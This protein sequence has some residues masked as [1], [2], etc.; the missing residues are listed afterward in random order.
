MS[1]SMAETHG[2]NVSILMVLLSFATVA[3]VVLSHKALCEVS[4]EL[5]LLDLMQVTQ[6]FWGGCRNYLE[7]LHRNFGKGLLEKKVLLNFLD[8]LFSGEI[9]CARSNEIY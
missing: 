2:E 9:S 1:V 4:F 7:A 6:L 3:H 8:V 5:S